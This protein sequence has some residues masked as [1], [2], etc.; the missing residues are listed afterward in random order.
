MLGGIRERGNLPIH[1]FKRGGV[2]IALFLGHSFPVEKLAEDHRTLRVVLHLHGMVI[3]DYNLDAGLLKYV[4]FLVVV[5]K[6]RA[7]YQQNIRPKRQYFFRVEDVVVIPADTR[8]SFQFRKCFSIDD[9]LAVPGFLPTVERHAYNLIQTPRSADH[10]KIG[11]VVCDDERL[12][13]F[14]QLDLA[15]SNIGK[16]NRR[17]SQNRFSGTPQKKN[18]QRASHHHTGEPSPNVHHEPLLAGISNTFIK[19]VLCVKRE[20]IQLHY[21]Y[22]Y[23]LKC[24]AVQASTR[25][26]ESSCATPEGHSMGS[27]TALCECCLSTSSVHRS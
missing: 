15:P 2:D 24:N 11:D 6:L 9:I 7:P 21:I 25:R 12:G 1:V 26:T 4:D 16:G 14:I 23:S 17:S 13:E 18:R 22:K 8:D 27:N 5:R 3:K 19:K 10:Q 20:W